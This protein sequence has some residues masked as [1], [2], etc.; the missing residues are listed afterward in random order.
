MRP[1]KHN[2]VIKP[3]AEKLDISEALVS[4]VSGFYWS[5]VKNH[6]KSLEH[7]R[8]SIINLGSFV[9]KD[10]SMKKMIKKYKNIHA[11]LIREESKDTTQ[12]EKV[13]RYSDMMEKLLVKVDLEKVRYQEKRKERKEY[14]ANKTLQ[15]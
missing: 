4:D 15:K 6:L 7:T 1:V 14:V 13:Q 5:S 12:L 9:V 11:K 10:A 3:T 2:E 8:I